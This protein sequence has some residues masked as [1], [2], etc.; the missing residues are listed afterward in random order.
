VRRAG[1]RDEGKNLVILNRPLLAVK[2]LSAPCDRLAFSAT[3]E[4]ARSARIHIFA[5]C[6]AS[7]GRAVLP[8]RNVRIAP[9]H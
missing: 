1:L 7:S 9:Q 2:D 4:N 5:T 3:R 6:R 8:R